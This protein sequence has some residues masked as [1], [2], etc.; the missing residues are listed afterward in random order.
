[1]LYEKNSTPTIYLKGDK[2]KETRIEPSQVKNFSQ[3]V[4]Y[5]NNSTIILGSILKTNKTSDLPSSLNS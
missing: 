2:K 5:K 4:I 3:K 1:L